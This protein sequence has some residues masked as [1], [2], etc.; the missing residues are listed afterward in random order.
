M[1][2]FAPVLRSCRLAAQLTQES[3]A[4]ASGVSVEAIRALEGGRRRHPRLTTVDLLADGLRL[5]EA[6][7]ARLAEAAM[8]PKK[9]KADGVPRDLPDDIADFTGRQEQLATLTEL[10]SAVERRGVLV[11]SAIEGMGG[12]GK[13]AL[14][15]HLAHRLADQF[16][17]GQLYLNLRGFG[18]GEPLPPLE[19]LIQLMQNLGLSSETRP[20][21]VDEASARFRTAIA[22]RRLLLVLD[23]AA[24]VG[25]IIPLLP[26]TGT[27]AVIVTSRRSLTSLPGAKHIMLEVLPDDDA[28][29]LFAEVA[30]A[31]RIA[32]EPAEALEVVRFCGSLPLALRIAAAQLAAHPGWTVGDLRDRLADEHGRLDLL[33]G[34]DL[35]VRA[36]LALSLDNLTE[37]EEP[38]GAIFPLL[39]AYQ[40]GV[41][42]LLV[43][44]RL[45]ALPVDDAETLLENLVDLHLLEMVDVRRYRLH[46]L[47]RDYAAELAA[48]TLSDEEHSAAQLR[49]LEFYAQMGRYL[50]RLNRGT[51][52]LSAWGGTNWGEWDVGLDLDFGQMLAWVDTEMPEIQSALRR[53]LDGPLEHRPLIALTVIGLD[54]YWN[55][56]RRYADSLAMYEIAAQAEKTVGDQHVQAILWYDWATMLAELRD[57]E[58]AAGRM[59]VAL[60]AETTA[61]DPMHLLHCLIYLGAYLGQLGHHEE[62]LGLAR[63]G[64]AIALD[65]GHEISIAEAR[66]MV[67]ALL[68]RSGQAAEQDESLAAAAAQIRAAEDQA[69]ARHWVLYRI[70]VTYH[71][72]GRYPEALTYLQE[73]LVV[74]ESYGE[75]VRAET[76]E[77]LGITELAAGNAKEAERQVRAALDIAVRDGNWYL[78]ARRRWNLGQVLVELG[79]VD[80]ARAEWAR[81]LELYERHGFA[82]ADDVRALLAQHP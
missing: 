56:R 32:A 67:G 75:V 59:R 7:R 27:C 66:L 42:D 29:A 63:Q 44:A 17:D 30:G 36:S 50:R 68:V 10:M 19:A 81:A 60:A 14:A 11:I 52:I 16:P 45:L 28:L 73:C 49:V 24:S 40:G 46:D 55:M 47:V 70:G 58:A 53:A 62:G 2:D 31:D 51:G 48:Q 12:V 22:G 39:G 80:E 4:E 9:A 23:N 65:V 18:A 6:G 61:D 13:T 57:F 41:L 43:A 54:P 5:D 72:C 20:R 82:Q 77:Q 64:L 38:A 26:G 37:S 34:D 74:D 79:Q 1:P 25:Q 71:E 33:S 3:L 76:L 8:R 69:F 15:I 21:S 35:N 78:E